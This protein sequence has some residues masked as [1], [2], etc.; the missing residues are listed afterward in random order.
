[1]KTFLIQ[2]MCK[3]GEANINGNIYTKESYDKAFQSEEFKEKLNNGCV[4][5]RESSIGGLDPTIT[6]SIATVKNITDDYIEIMPKNESICD[7]LDKINMDDV[8]IGM[9]YLADN[10]IDN[11]DGTKTWNVTR[12][13]SFTLIDKERGEDIHVLK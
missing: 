12:I 5:V 8:R 3:P 13:I 10:S 7:A 2:R 11:E 6:E 9:N 1:M 4:F